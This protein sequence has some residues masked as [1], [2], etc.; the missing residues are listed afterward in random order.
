[1]YKVASFRWSESMH[2]GINSM[3]ALC[4]SK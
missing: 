2:Q 3:A 1:M 4:W